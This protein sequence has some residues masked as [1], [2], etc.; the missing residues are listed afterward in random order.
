MKAK[1][2]KKR[3]FAKLDADPVK[4]EAA[5]KRRL[6]LYR[7]AQKRRDAKMTEEQR[8]NL[9]KERY[10]ANKALREKKR[11]TTYGGFSSL[12]SL[13]WHNLKELEANGKANEADLAKLNEFRRKDREAKKRQYKRLSCVFGGECI[14]KGLDRDADSSRIDWSDIED[15]VPMEADKEWRIY[16]YQLHHNVKEGKPKTERQIRWEREK[17]L[18]KQLKVDNPEKFRLRAERRK[19]TQARARERYL[20]KQRC[21]GEQCPQMKA[22]NLARDRVRARKRTANRK[23]RTGYTS[24]KN[25]KFDKLRTLVTEGRASPAQEAELQSLREAAKLSNRKRTER[26]TLLR[27][28]ND[29]KRQKTSH[30]VHVLDPSSDLYPKLRMLRRSVCVLSI[31]LVMTKASVYSVP[32]SSLTSNQTRAEGEWSGLSDIVEINKFDPSWGQEAESLPKEDHIKNSKNHT[33]PSEAANNG[34]AGGKKRFYPRSKE[35]QKEYRQRFNEKVK[36]DPVRNKFYKERKKQWNAKWEANYTSKFTSQEKEAYELDKRS[37]KKQSNLRGR[38]R[39]GGFSCGKMQRLNQIRNL[40]AKGAASEEDLKFLHD[41]RASERERRKK[42]KEAREGLARKGQLD[43]MMITAGVIYVLLFL[44]FPG[45]MKAGEDSPSHFLNLDWDKF[46][47]L[48][49]FHHDGVPSA[50]LTGDH[51]TS[52]AMVKPLLKDNEQKPDIQR[53]KRPYTKKIVSEKEYNRIR[54][55]KARNVVQMKLANMSE[56]EVIAY[57]A[58]ITQKRQ[59]RERIMKEKTGYRTPTQYKYHTLKRLVESNQANQAQENEFNRLKELSRKA[60]ARAIQR[61]RAAGSKKT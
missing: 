21:L 28:E 55:M 22:M 43:T 53:E 7:L 42:A 25:E 30:S 26:R 58:R 4:K 10:I 52:K 36:S 39:F 51:V 41:Y 24:L 16:Q 23:A 35:K 8:R 46:D 61:K 47:H 1:E 50:P 18:R 49:E 20:A 3:Y 48:Y 37:R 2:S 11:V 59:D 32:T 14:E 45:Y 34:K 6:E 54:G 60:S 27:L 57:K 17:E 29:S 19:Q 15:I 12:K 31:A 5:H 33:E 56:A 13:E 40:Q 38:A 44:L 9:K